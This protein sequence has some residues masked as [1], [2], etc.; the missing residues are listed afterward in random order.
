MSHDPIA[1]ALPYD[2]PSVGTCVLTGADGE[3]PDDCDT[4]DHETQPAWHAVVH[5]VVPCFDRNGNPVDSV[6]AAQDYI[7]ETL[8]NQF[9]DWGYLRAT[10]PETGEPVEGDIGLQQPIPIVVCQPYVE[11]TFLDVAD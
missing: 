6:A 11:G 4:H 8:R 7:S 3:N 1:D 5:L 9:L 10:D 2:H